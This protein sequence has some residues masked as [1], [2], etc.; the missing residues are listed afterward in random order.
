M[1]KSRKSFSEYTAVQNGRSVLSAKSSAELKAIGC[2][3]VILQVRTDRSWI[4]AKL[5]NVLH[6]QDLNKNLFSLTAVTARGMTVTMDSEKCVVKRGDHVVATGRKQ[7]KLMYLNTELS[8]ECYAAGGDAELWHRRLGHVSFSTLNTMIADGKLA[9]APMESGNV[10]EVCATAK[11]SRKPFSSTKEELEA[12]ES[13]RKDTAVCSDVLG[14]I[15]PISKSGHKYIATF[16]LM[17]SRY[18]TIY[19]MRNKNEVCAAFQNFLKEIRTTARLKIKVLRSDNGG[20]Y[21][22]KSMKTLCDDKLIKHEFTVPHNP[23][24][25]GIAERTNR[26]LVEMTRCILKESGLDKSYWCEA[27]MTA[28]DIRNVLPN[29]SNQHSS[30]FELVFKRAPRLDHM[31]VFGTEC[32]AHVPKQKRK[33]LDDTGVKCVFLGYA[34]QRKAYRLLEVSDGSIVISRSVTF[35]EAPLVKVPRDAMEGVFDIT[36]DNDAE[37]I[38]NEGGAEEGFRTP[39][40]RPRQEPAFR[41]EQEFPNLRR[42]QFNLDDFEADHDSLYCL[43]TEDDD[44]ERAV[45]YDEVMKSK[46]NGEWLHAMGSEMKS[47]EDHQTWTLVDMPSDKKAIGCKWGFRIKRDPNDSI[48]KFKARLVA[49]GFTQRPGIDYTET[50][51]PVAR[52]ESI[53]AV[54]AIAAEEDMEAEN[55]DVDT[56]FLYGDVEE[57]LYMDQPDGF[58]DQPTRIRSACWD[59]NSTYSI[60]IVYVDDLM[61]FSRTKDD[62][63]EIKEAL[64]SEFSIKELGDLKYCLGI[65]I[66]R[67]R[68]KMI[69]MNQRAYIKRLAEKS[70]VDKCKDIY[71]PADSSAKLMKS[72]EDEYFV[73]KYPYRELVGALMYLATSTRPD[74]AYAVG[75]V[76]K[77]CERYNKSHWVAAKRILKYL[78]TTQD[79]GLVFNGGIKGELVGYADANWAGDLDTRR[80]TTGY[81]FFFNGSAISWKSKRQPTVATSSTEAEYMALYNAI[82]EAVWLRQLLKDLGYEN[83]GTTTIYQENQGCIAL[84]KNPAYHTRTKHIDIKFHFLHEKVES[85]TVELEYKPTD[86]MMIADGFTKALARANTIS[87]SMGYA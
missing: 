25:N 1:C 84:A 17:K 63:A 37:D 72:S 75:E 38:N 20:E 22:N 49:K 34:K 59:K 83:K 76:A 71:T 32:Y 19:P 27:M 81:V 36:N 21:W 15:T 29:T 16:I 66:H 31:R 35:A 70:G 55:V 24:Q 47:L 42:G 60:V 65:E 58:A 12:R 46:Y 30:P 57:E 62:I 26:T 79:V 44:G 23:E 86:E 51:A 18:L 5:E 48:V 14:P 13:A 41:Y 85:K 45:T 68:E 80:S 67:K 53:N 10:C 77:F 28:A 64:R 73:A 43:H 11:Q 3:T 8:E 69:V 7:G 56:A 78:K 87:S 2:G 61:I 6:V 50:F 40:T 9:G 54:A 4:N 74:I 39:P 52:K 82:Q 33:K